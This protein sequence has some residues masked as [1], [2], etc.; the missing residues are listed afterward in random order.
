[1]RTRL[2][3]LG[4]YTSATHMEIA[5]VEFHT[6]SHIRTV[7]GTEVDAAHLYSILVAITRSHIRLTGSRG[8]IGIILGSDA[9]II[10][11]IIAHQGKTILTGKEAC[12]LHSAGML[13]RQVEVV[14]LLRLQIRIT[15]NHL[16]TCHIKVHIHLLEGWGTESAGIVGTDGETLPL[17]H[18]SQSTG[19][20]MLTG[21]REV[22]MTKTCHDVQPL[23]RIVI[24][25][26]EGIT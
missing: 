21:C 23:Q 18:Q 14:A 10:L 9:L 5:V 6:E 7:L 20:G 24:E 3:E 12:I 13:Q 2:G 11:I 19:S 25:L 26:G 15:V 4:I 8:I 22:I 17:G 1:M 16:H